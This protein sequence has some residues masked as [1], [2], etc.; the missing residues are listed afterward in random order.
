[1]RRFKSSQIRQSQSM[2]SL[3]NYHK[4]I[5]LFSSIDFH[6]WSSRCSKLHWCFFLLFFTKI[7][8][9]CGYFKFL[10]KWKCQCVNEDFIDFSLTCRMIHSKHF[11]F[12]CRILILQ[13]IESPQRQAVERKVHST[14]RLVFPQRMR[15]SRVRH[16]DYSWS[17]KANLT[18]R[19]D[20]RLTCAKRSWHRP[21]S[22][23]SD[24]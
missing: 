16:V 13:V 17:A 22:F 7:L 1:M 15:Q 3:R 14:Q 20:V 24:D 11:F 19:K 18:A 21:S 2:W 23:G 12:L 6:S 5:Y 10:K 9:L 8:L 4:V